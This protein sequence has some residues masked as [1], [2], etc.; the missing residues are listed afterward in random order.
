VC[1]FAGFVI[2]LAGSTGFYLHVRA[3]EL[4]VSRQDAE[5]ITLLIG[6][7]A[8]VLVA[9]CVTGDLLLRS[10]R[11]RRVPRASSASA[12]TSATLLERQYIASERSI[13]EYQQL[14]LEQA[15]ISFKQSQ[16][17]M[18][19]ALLLLLLG[20]ASLLVVRNLSGQLMVGGLTLLG[21]GFSAFLSTTFLNVFRQSIG[22]LN[23][24]FSVPV[25]KNLV[26]LANM[27]AI[28]RQPDDL[29]RDVV[30]STL[31]A[32]PGH[33]AA[34]ATSEATAAKAAPGAEASAAAEDPVAESRP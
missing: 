3:E 14:A 21:S 4:H 24:S 15:K 11:E 20:G 34:A 26:I 32:L 8:V 1:A 29:L 30:H 28:S 16:R 33:P 31:S 10:R 5:R 2:A 12:P 17:A 7:A 25:T 23:Q 9:A 13:D 22:Q 18:A 27:L 19:A 6:V